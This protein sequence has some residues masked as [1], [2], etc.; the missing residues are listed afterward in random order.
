LIAVRTLF[1]RHLNARYHRFGRRSAILPQLTFQMVLKT[2]LLPIH[3]RLPIAHAFL[4]APVRLIVTN[5][6]CAAQFTK[7]RQIAVTRLSASL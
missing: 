2:V 3:C 4:I 6:T 1:D 7:T 5:R